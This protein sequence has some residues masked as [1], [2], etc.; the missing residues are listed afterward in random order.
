[1]ILVGGMVKNSRCLFACFPSSWCYRRA[2][3]Q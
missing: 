2:K 3:V 1:M